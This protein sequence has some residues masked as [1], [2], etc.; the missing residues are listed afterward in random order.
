MG[1]LQNERCAMNRDALLGWQSLSFS[2]YERHK[3]KKGSNY[4]QKQISLSLWKEYS[5]Y[6]YVCWF[7][8][9]GKKNKKKHHHCY[10]VSPQ[11][12]E[13]E[14][15]DYNIYI[16]SAATYSWSLSRT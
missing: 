14:V 13:E 8:Y 4:V 5:R 12:Q 9:S 1:T 6:I 10:Y 3:D 11:T 2:P 7:W 16:K 15:C